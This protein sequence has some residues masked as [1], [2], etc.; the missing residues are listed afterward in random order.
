MW[1]YM[2][3]G[4]QRGPVLENDFEG[5]RREGKIHAETFVWR[6]GMTDWQTLGQ[7]EAAG[8][9][10]GAAVAPP[11]VP[12]AG[13]AICSQCGGRFPAGEVIHY[14][15]AAVCAGCKPMFIQRLREGAKVVA[16]PMDYAGF[17]IRFAAYFLDNIIMGFAGL[18]VTAMTG[19]IIGV[20]SG[21][22]RNNAFAVTIAVQL[23]SMGL[24]FAVQA[25]YYIYFIG[26]GGQTPGKMLCRVRVVNADGTAVSYAKATGRFFA[27]FLSSLIFLIGFLMAGWDEQKRALHDR[28]CETRVIKVG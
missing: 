2:E 4:Q 23:L 19:A 22:S 21:V 1:Y 8:A 16:G 26:H 5:L 9:G 7:V 12:G 17:W 18:I 6:D 25:A 14:G 3:D 28:I 11:V 27:Y 24:G 20:S 15:G 10:S 13:E